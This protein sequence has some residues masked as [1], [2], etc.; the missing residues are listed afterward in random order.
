M[1]KRIPLILFALMLFACSIPST[2]T[3]PVATQPSVV[4][5]TPIVTVSPPLATNVTC[6]ELSFYLDPALASGFNCQTIPE[7][8][9]PDRPDWDVNPQY[10]KVTLQGYVLSDRFFTP[11]IDVFPVQRYVELF[12]ETINQ[13]V[14]SLQSLIGGAAPVDITLPLLPV[15]NAA[16]EFYVKYQVLPFV[17]GE[18]IHFITEYAQSYDPINNYDM[19]FT[20]QG[21]TT[22]GKYWISAIFP[23]SHPSLP[24]NGNNP[25]NGQSWDDFGNNFAS[26]ITGITSNLD[27]Q[28]IQSFIPGLG[29]LKTLVTSITIQP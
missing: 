21:L 11:H 19:F 1:K 4:T 9:G 20:Y 3:Q 27:A 14:A 17:S 8:S 22:D 24:E 7:V 23:V 28:P 15:F 2:P 10:T 16:Q 12:P 25:P 6:N 13:R 26:Y 5:N 18:G 29:V